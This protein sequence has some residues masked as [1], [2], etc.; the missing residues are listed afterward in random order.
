VH[1]LNSWG[2]RQPHEFKAHT[3]YWHTEAVSG[4]ATRKICAGKQQFKHLLYGGNRVLV[5]FDETGGLRNR[6]SV[7]GFAE[8]AGGTHP[9]PLCTTNVQSFVAVRKFHAASF[10]SFRVTGAGVGS[11]HFTFGGRQRIPEW[12]PPSRQN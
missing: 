11:P 2:K 12:L 8:S 10:S 9:D 3:N 6:L 4:L 5:E 1:A 7:T